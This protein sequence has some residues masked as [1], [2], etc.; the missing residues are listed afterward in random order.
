MT[1]EETGA[2]N[3][4]L[5]YASEPMF[6]LGHLGVARQSLGETDMASSE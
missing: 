5:S 3:R 6:P 4:A 1:L 2:S